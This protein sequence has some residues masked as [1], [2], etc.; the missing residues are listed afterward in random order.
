[1][2]LTESP[3]AARRRLRF[4]L[5]RLRESAQLTQG[6][7]SKRLDWSI[8]KVNRIETGEVTVSGTDLE[9]MLRLF[10]VAGSISAEQLVSHCKTARKR[11]WWSASA[12]RSHVT[13]ALIELLQYESDAIRIRAYGP[14]VM[15]G[16]FQTTE[17]GSA[18]LSYFAGDLSEDERVARLELRTHLRAN[19]IDREPGPRCVLLLDES[20]VTREVGGPQLM[21]DQLNDLLDNIRVGKLELRIVPLSGPAIFAMAKAFILLDLDGDDVVMYREDALS[22]EMLDDT[23]IIKTH[24]RLFAQIEVRTLTTKASIRL[25]EARIAAL[26]YELDRA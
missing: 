1:M 7:V 13:P 18:I 25:I 12:F 4:A 21:V 23:E 5:R 2:M 24:E 16:P 15:P 8:S 14:V 9:A 11:G 26:M 6:D 17:Y 3:A 20:V 19:A 10:G 22:D